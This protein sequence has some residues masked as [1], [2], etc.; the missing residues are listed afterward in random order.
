VHGT[1]PGRRRLLKVDEDAFRQA[2]FV[3]MRALPFQDSVGKRRSDWAEIQG[4]IVHC[5]DSRV[6]EDEHHTGIR[7]RGS[8]QKIPVPPN[9]RRFPGGMSTAE[10]PGARRLD[11]CKLE[12]NWVLSFYKLLVE[13]LPE[14][15]ARQ[16]FSKEAHIVFT[17][18]T[19][20]ES[21]SFDEQS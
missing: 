21:V 14:R 18:S 4:S 11:Q 10:D 6:S 20:R 17:K 12:R 5:P 19:R 8:I 3:R 9:S 13:H 15:L 16:V 7:T 1:Y 2:N